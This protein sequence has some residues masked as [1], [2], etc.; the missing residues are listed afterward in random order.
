MFNTLFSHFYYAHVP[1]TNYFQK[2]MSFASLAYKENIHPSIKCIFL[3]SPL[4]T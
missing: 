4:I 1:K 3:K 2:Q